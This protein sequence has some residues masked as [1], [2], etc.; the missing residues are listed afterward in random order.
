MCWKEHLGEILFI[1]D[2]VFRRVF[3][4]GWWLRLL[5]FFFSISYDSI[6][7]GHFCFQKEEPFIFYCHY[8]YIGSFAL[9]LYQRMRAGLSP[10]WAYDGVQLQGMATP[11][12][13]TPTTSCLT[14]VKS[15]DKNQ[16]Q[17]HIYFALSCN[18]FFNKFL[19][20][21][22]RVICEAFRLCKHVARLKQT[23]EEPKYNEQHIDYSVHFLH[24]VFIIHSIQQR[25]FFEFKLSL[26]FTIFVS[27]NKYSHLEIICL[28]FGSHFTFMFFYLLYPL[29]IRK[30]KQRK[31][32]SSNF[33]C[34]SPNFGAVFCKILHISFI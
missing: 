4:Q 11:S 30:I 17:I 13:I 9:S 24:V 20:I 23:V 34:Q 21:D 12:P 28:W 32:N 27:I 29:A 16:I 5:W 26:Y 14:T 3:H 1:Q 8:L 22:I 25:N 33:L 7:I 2:C 6:L 19:V 15:C 18:T 10:V 31:R